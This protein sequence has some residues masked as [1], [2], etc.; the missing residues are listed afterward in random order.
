MSSLD[1]AFVKED[2]N[3]LIEAV[4]DWEKLNTREYAMMMAIKN[5][6]MP[7]E[8]NETYG[9]IKAL[10]QQASQH[11]KTITQEKEFNQERAVFLKAKLYLAKKDVEINGL[12]NLSDHV[13][14]EGPKGE[15]SSKRLELAEKFIE[16]MGVQSYYD[17]YLQENN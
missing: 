6:P 8:D 10:K 7:S 13:S 9:T 2:I 14:D 15:F 3:I 11:E 4:D 12:F 16:G 5:M 1:S 17:K